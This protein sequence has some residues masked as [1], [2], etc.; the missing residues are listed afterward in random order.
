MTGRSRVLLVLVLLVAGACDSGPDEGPGLEGAGPLVVE[1]ARAAKARLDDIAPAVAAWNG[2]G[3]LPG[4]LAADMTAV[5][6]AARAVV[7]AAEPD[8]HAGAA[9]LSKAVAEA[10]NDVVRHLVTTAGGREEAPGWMVFDPSSPVAF[11]TNAEVAPPPGPLL[12]ASRRSRT[13][14]G[15]IEAQEGLENDIHREIRH[16]VYV[17]LLA[18][19]AT[20]A[21]LAPRLSPDD[22]PAVVPKDLNLSVGTREEWKQDLFDHQNRLIVPSAFDSRRWRSFIGWTEVVSPKLNLVAEELAS[23]VPPLAKG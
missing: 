13:E 4:S 16:F 5:G 3:E 20:R 23:R 19:P 15:K 22:L 7:Q 2:E 21:A 14:L 6:D 18:H 9:A 17:A 1:F 10:A 12:E 8:G 11:D